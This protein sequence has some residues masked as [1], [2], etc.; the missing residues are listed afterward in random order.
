MGRFQEV[1]PAYISL[2]EGFSRWGMKKRWDFLYQETYEH[3]KRSDPSATTAQLILRTVTALLYLPDHI[4]PISV[5]DACGEQALEEIFVPSPWGIGDIWKSIKKKISKWV[6]SCADIA[7]AVWKWIKEKV[8]AMI[9]WVKDHLLLVII[10]VVIIVIII[11]LAIFAPGFLMKVLETLATILSKVFSW[12]ATVYTKASEWVEKI[13][14]WLHLRT[15]QQVIKGIKAAHTLLKTISPQYRDLVARWTEDI[16]ELS[17]N[18]F[19]DA[20]T[21]HNALVLI[22]MAVYDVTRLQGKPVDLAENEYFRQA[23]DLTGKIEKRL[24]IYR[25]SPGRFWYDVQKEFIEPNYKIAL[26]EHKKGQREVAWAVKGVRSVADMAQ[27][28]DKRFREYQRHMEG[29]IPDRLRDRLFTLER[30]VD[31]EVIRP[32]QD[33]RRTVDDTFEIVEGDVSSLKEDMEGVKKD[34][35]EVK[36]ITADPA[37]LSDEERGKQRRR[38][39]SILD[40]SLIVPSLAPEERLRR[41]HERILSILEEIGG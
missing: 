25:R 2:P 37:T 28:I 35:K 12:G 33:L 4:L 5:K 11:L 24:D 1:V 23:V 13:K 20:V 21:I 39:L 8:Q 17:A 41:K 30:K 6:S 18:I 32:L 38:I 15:V 16:R 7:N 36:T 19:G 14:G 29:I 40:S 22:Q 34:L 3:F 27:D 26:D 9:D 10:I 31:M